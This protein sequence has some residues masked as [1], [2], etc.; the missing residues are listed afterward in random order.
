MIRDLQCVVAAT[1]TGARLDRWLTRQC[2]S[3]ARAQAEAAMRAAGEGAVA[4][5]GERLDH[6]RSR[7]RLLTPAAQIEQ[8]C[9]RLDDLANRLAAALRATLQLRGQRLG[10]IRARL[11]QASP[12]TRVQLGSHQLLSLY[13]R[14]QAAS[15]ASV[16]HR[17]F[18]IVRDEQGQPVARRAAIRAGQRLSA[19]FSDGAV[20]VQAE[21]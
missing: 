7:L 6:A 3:V 18:A 14:L 15:P 1:E 4:R 11:A 20:P 21:P 9:L 19:E 8:G 12:E 5:A 10:E 17:G 13:K 16:L 2:P